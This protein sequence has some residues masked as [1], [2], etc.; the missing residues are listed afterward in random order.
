MIDSLPK[1]LLGKAF[2]FK[3]ACNK[4]LTQYAIQKLLA[5]GVIQKL[6]RG[7]YSSVDEDLSDEE[8][9]R[10][11]V[12]RVGK[13]AVV[14][15]LSALSYYELTDTI[16]RQVWL[17]VPKEKRVKSKSV[18][19]YR[20]RAPQWKVGI[21]SKEGYSITSIERTIVDALTLKTLLSPRMGVDALKTAIASKKTSA[22]RV[23]Q[24]AS[25]LGVKHRV[26]PYIE[27]LS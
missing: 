10:R 19:L 3:E 8:D 9:Y 23:L 25:E 17:M 12:K 18:K 15:L 2:T 7:L 4:G 27:A 21:L 5:S 24:I 20:A 16:P 6:E 22:N 14:C 13:P 11:A 26:L 1:T